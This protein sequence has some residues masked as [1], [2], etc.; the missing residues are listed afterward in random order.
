V[1]DIRRGFSIFRI[2]Q[3][4]ENIIKQIENGAI[5][6]QISLKNSAFGYQ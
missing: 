6:G 2:Q 1:T 5:D 3:E 4:L